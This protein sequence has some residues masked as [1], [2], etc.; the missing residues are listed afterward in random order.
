MKYDNVKFKKVVKIHANTFFIF[1]IQK[2]MQIA[3]QP[4]LMSCPL[5]QQLDINKLATYYF[6]PQLYN[7]YYN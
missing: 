2:I 5:I 1:Y 6:V 3:T 7:I 4:M